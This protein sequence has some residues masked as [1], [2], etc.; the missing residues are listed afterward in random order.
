LVDTTARLEDRGRDAAG[1]QFGDQQVEV[2]QLGGETA[3]PVAVAV[4]KAFLAAFMAVSSAIR[5][6]ALLPSSS[7]TSS[8]AAQAQWV[9][10]M[11]CLV[12]VVLEPGKRAC[13][14]LATTAVEPVA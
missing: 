10:G 7:E 5:S 3:G 6:P 11:V 13:P 1:T 14:P 2:S 12:V 8:G 4:A 9:L